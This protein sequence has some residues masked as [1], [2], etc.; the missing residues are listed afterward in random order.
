MNSRKLIASVLA[1]LMLISVL[2]FSAF[3]A[4]FTKE[5]WDSYYAD[6]NGE[7]SAAITMTPGSDE[8]ERYISWYSPSATGKVVLTNALGVEIEYPATAKQTAQG[9]YR[10][11][12]V[13]EGLSPE[14]A[15]S[16]RCVSEGFESAEY[17]IAP[18][19]DEFTAMYVTDIHV[20]QSDDN[21]NAVRDTAYA[22]N[23]TVS[24]AQ[25]KA[26]SRGN[27]LDLIL[28]AGD[29]ASNGNRAEYTGV[30]ASPFVRTIPF[31]T[32]IGNHD[33]KSVDYRFFTFQPNT[34]EMKIKSYVGTDYWFTKGDVLFLV[35][36]SN[37]PSM[38]DH[39]AFVKEAVEENPDTKWRVAVFHHDLYSARIP[40]RESENALLRIMWA[41]IA[42]EFGIDLCLLGHSHYYTVSNVLYNNKTVEKTFNGATVLN[43]EGT[44]YMVSGSIN[45]P[46][47]D[48]ELGLS[49]NI[50]HAYLTSEKI[51][52]LLTF[53]ENSIEINSYTVES[54]TQIGNLTILKTSNEGGHSYTT[55][56][57]WYY[58]AIEFISAIVAIV[59]NI[60]VLADNLELGFDVP[61]F[62]GIFG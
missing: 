22:F 40:H 17:I 62:E 27:T 45:N 26:V 31:E 18:T 33:R 11:Q 46:R 47:N 49:E 1:A 51:Y 60:G 21:E 32:T 55:P 12:A 59:N 41:P 53:S 19:G 44:V 43:P 58:P 16:Y 13:I 42:D 24:A 39:K 4:D 14:A 10:L 48:D 52:N 20:S 57:K 5:A 38:A 9:D 3:A 54:D 29:Q 28:S 35:M 6:A 30:A 25:K 36:D 8:T 34:A 2:P 23:Q 56:A 61:L 50:G 37:N 7:I 15:Y